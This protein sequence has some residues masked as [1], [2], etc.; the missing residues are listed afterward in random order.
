[1]T[2]T[3]DEAIERFRAMRA[4]LMAALDGLTD[5]Q[6]LET[7][8][9]GWSVKDNIV[10]IA[11]WDDLRADEVTRISAG[12]DS[13]LKMTDEQ[14]DRLNDL[15]HEFRRD[16]SL[17]QARWEL[18]HSHERLVAALLAATPRGLDPAHYGDASLLTPHD[19]IHAE[20]LADW[21]KKMGY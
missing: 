11:F 12:Y 16:L 20:F 17:E 9:D 7:T 5:A 1:M 21:R 8:V 6:M 15:A 2:E 10:H 13:V 4:R 18:L 19:A 3:A 14:D